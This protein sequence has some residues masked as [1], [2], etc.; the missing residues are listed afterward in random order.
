MN[1]KHILLSIM[2]GCLAGI[3]GGSLGTSGLEFMLPMLLLLGVVSDYKTAA[4]TV[5]LT[6]LPPI[7]LAAVS[8]YYKRGEVQVNTAVIL[9]ICY[10][11]VSGYVARLVKDIPNKT[12]MGYANIYFFLISC[13][14][15][16]MY[17]YY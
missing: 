4:G 17:L 12:L 16:Y 1:V 8:H 10:F 9:F 15:Y 6:V 11:M 3:F 5:L 14:F 13:L 2:I 7:T